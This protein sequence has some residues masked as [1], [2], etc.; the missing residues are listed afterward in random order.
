MKNTISEVKNTQIKLDEAQDQNT[1][2]EDKVKKKK[3][4][5]KKLRKD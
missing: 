3:K 4:Q 1:E 2:S 5:S